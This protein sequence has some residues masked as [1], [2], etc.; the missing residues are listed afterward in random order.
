MGWAL[1]LSLASVFYYIGNND[2]YNKGWLL[3]LASIACSFL[4]FATGLSLLGAFGANVLL[5]LIL[6]FY[7]LLTRRPPGSQSGF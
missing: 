3:A 5:Y 6:F 4:G 1:L 7:N 2:Y